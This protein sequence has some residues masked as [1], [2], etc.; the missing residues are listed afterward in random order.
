MP[1]SVNLTRSEALKRARTAVGAVFDGAN[2]LFVGT[3]CLLG[4]M[5]SVEDGSA[6]PTTITCRHVIDRQDLSSLI[7]RMPGADMPVAE[8]QKMMNIS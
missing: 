2:G 8:M 1:R 6:K 5:R 3:T 7:L 4:V